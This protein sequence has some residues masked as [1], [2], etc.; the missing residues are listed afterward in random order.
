MAVS[1]CAFDDGSAPIFPAETCTFC[2]SIAL[3]TSDGISEYEASFAGSSQMRIAYSAP[4]TCKLPTPS[5]RASGSWT[6]LTSQ[7]AMSELLALSVL[8]YTPMISRKLLWDFTTVMPDCCTSLGRRD[9]ACCT[10]FCTC[11]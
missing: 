11:T 4:N 10:L 1:C 9:S 5:T 7:S 2:A 8:S 6:L 3:C